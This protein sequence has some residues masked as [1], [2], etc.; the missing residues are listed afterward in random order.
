MAGVSI[1][2]VKHMVHAWS[3]EFFAHIGWGFRL[4]DCL[5]AT[6]KKILKECLQALP[7]SPQH[8]AP[9]PAAVS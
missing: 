3:S 8:P 9:V 7:L 2:A 6:L 5:L 1:R 4:H